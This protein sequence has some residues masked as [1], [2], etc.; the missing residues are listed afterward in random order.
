MLLRKH[1]NPI[2]N[3]FPDVGSRAA[4]SVGFVDWRM[5][6]RSTSRS[7]YKHSPFLPMDVP[8]V[9]SFLPVHGK[10]VA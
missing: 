10:S 6:L 4:W 5:V 1:P 9:A 8:G 3:G 2:S 7:F